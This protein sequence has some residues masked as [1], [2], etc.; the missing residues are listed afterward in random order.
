LV[1][2]LSI[3]IGIGVMGV[4]YGVDYG[5]ARGVGGNARGVGGGDSCEALNVQAAVGQP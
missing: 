3:R 2:A 1:A 5:N 4:A